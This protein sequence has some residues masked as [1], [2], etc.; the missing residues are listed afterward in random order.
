[1]GK[2]MKVMFL[3]FHTIVAHS[4]ISKKILAQVEGLR[5][6]GAEVSLCSLVI[7][8]D[9]RKYRALDSRPICEFGG[10]LKAKIRKR[11]DYSDIVES[12]REGGYDLIYIRYDINAD[13]FTVRMMK[14]LHQSGIRTIVEIPTY[15]YDGEFRGQGLMMNLQLAIDKLFRRRFFSYCDRIVLYSGPSSLHGR[16]VVHISNGV[17]FSSV[18]LSQDRNGFHGSLKLLSV[19]NI[20]LWHG[21][22]RLIR[23]MAEHKHIDCELHI[24]G[25]GV[26]QIIESYRTLAESL[27]IADKVK[28]LGPMYGKDLDREFGW[29]DMAV[30]SLGRHRSG[31]TSIKTLKN[32]EY[33]AR[34][35]AFFYSE[36]DEDFDNAPYVMKVPADE[37]AI[38]VKALGEFLSGLKMSGEEIR[39]SIRNLSWTAQMARIIE[40]IS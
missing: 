18:P 8:P 36:Q 19:A 27:G 37:S 39:Q 28:I 11:V 1:M 15:P 4:G 7:A 6:N 40:S 34:G 32:R 35:L 22:D 23:G 16:P 2:G 13:P 30:G 5:Q 25:D 3:V 14:M 21:L 31:I 9:G 10:G 26:P 38:D 29:A 24:V 33:A 20:H 17:D 12:A